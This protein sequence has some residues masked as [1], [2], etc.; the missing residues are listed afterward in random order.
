MRRADLAI[1]ATAIR[2]GTSLLT[3]NIR[4]FPMFTNLRAARLTRVVSAPRPRSLGDPDRVSGAFIVGPI[5]DL[6]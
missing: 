3:R 1:A 6:G 4:H 2:T 5:I